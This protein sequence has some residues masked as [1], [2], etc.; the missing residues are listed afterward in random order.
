MNRAH[1][2]IMKTL[3]VNST[4]IEKAPTDMC[5]QAAPT[6]KKTD[7]LDSCFFFR[8]AW[9]QEKLIVENDKIFALSWS[10][11]YES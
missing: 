2:I 7:G 5:P 10:P 11:S 4:I 6:D 3:L 1:P 8:L 9:V